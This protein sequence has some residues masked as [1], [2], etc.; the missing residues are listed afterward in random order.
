MFAGRC[1]AG[2]SLDDVAKSE[3]QVLDALF[4]EELG[5]VF[6]VRAKDE[7]RFNKA[8]AT[9][10]PPHG[11]IK[12]IG[13]VREADKESL[14]IKYRGKTLMDLDRTTLHQWW[15]GTSFEMQKLRDN[16]ACAQAEFDALSD[17][18][19][20]GLQ[21]KLKFDPSDLSL[22]SLVSLKSMISRPRGMSAI[23][24]LMATI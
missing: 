1:G 14:L 24:P 13:Y 10:G 3:G 19:D 17:T 4:N 5:A 21:Y 8:F 7:K 9:C 22:P 12:T 15:A 20:P 2:I 18:K 16:P 11:L 6:Q 23:Y